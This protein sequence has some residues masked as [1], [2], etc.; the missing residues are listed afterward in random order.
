MFLRNNPR[1][2]QKNLLLMG[3]MTTV[4]ALS[5]RIRLLDKN[6]QFVFGQPA[7]EAA[8]GRVEVKADQVVIGWL[9]LDRQDIVTDDIASRFMEQQ[10]RNIALIALFALLI[11]LVIALF[12]VRQVLIPVRKL[13]EGARHLS[14]GNF[15]TQIQINSND[16]LA[17]LASRFNQLATFLQRNEELRSQWI[18][19]ISHEL[20]T[21]I[22]IL[23]GE[24]EAMLD[25]LRKP[26]LER[27]RSLHTDTL[28]LG[29]LVEDLYQLSV[30]DADGM[31]IRQDFVPVDLAALLSDVLTVFTARL[32]TKSLD[33]QQQIASTAGLW[34]L[35]DAN[36]MHQLFSNL[37]ENS[38]R[39]TDA[40]GQIRVSASLDGNAVRVVIEDS[41]PGV[42][43][44]AL[45]KL[46][47]R[48]FRVDKSR[49][50]LMGGSGLGLS[51][52]K[53]LVRLHYGN[54]SAQH[55]ELG[56]IAMVIALPRLEAKTKPIAKGARN[57]NVVDS[58]QKQRK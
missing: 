54:I 18:A 24:I 43:D 15:D 52:C 28:S 21:P 26:D 44:V 25:G 57:G 39:Y 42:P 19:D 16:E 9:E 30:S 5:A 7:N 14:L 13:T 40:G 3:D 31:G 4:R 51:I 1:Q 2:W 35:A 50:R 22:A 27:I 11:S 23:R 49:S 58:Y 41:A 12:S 34:V 47:D 53:N 10:A 36:R 20:R 17:E 55:S 32:A 56:G 8:V 46:F 45:P 37:L 33:V 6:Q 48:L 38:F 29:Q